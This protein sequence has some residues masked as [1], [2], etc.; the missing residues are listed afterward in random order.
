MTVAMRHWALDA[1]ALTSKPR[2]SRYFFAVTT[3]E[4]TYAGTQISAYKGNLGAKVLLFFELCKY[5]CKI[6]TKVLQKVSAIQVYA[7]R[8]RYDLPTR[9]S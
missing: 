9:R 6:L 7:L 1:S 4:T 2:A 3:H 8:Q 5:F